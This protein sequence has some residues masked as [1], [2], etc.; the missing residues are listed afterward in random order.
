MH[1]RSDILIKCGAWFPDR[2]FIAICVFL[3]RL[4]R[5]PSQTNIHYFK[6]PNKFVIFV[7]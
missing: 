4:E 1:E 5:Q 7:V 3:E 2:L 6:Y